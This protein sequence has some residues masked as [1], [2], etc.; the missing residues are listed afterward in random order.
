[1]RRICKV[2]STVG[3]YWVLHCH[4]EA[5][6]V[7]ILRKLQA[8]LPGRERPGKALLCSRGGFVLRYL[9][10]MRLAKVRPFNE[11]ARVL[12]CLILREADAVP[13]VGVESAFVVAKRDLISGRFGLCARVVNR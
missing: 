13:Q 2:H 12:G 8:A 5:F 9:L 1:M 4:L 7:F 11:I 6:F 10:A 3:D